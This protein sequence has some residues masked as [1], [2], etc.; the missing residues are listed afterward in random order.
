MV[1]IKMVE[2]YNDEQ[3]FIKQVEKIMTEM[4]TTD[5]KFAVAHGDRGNLYSAMILK[6]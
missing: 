5:V 4:D 6:H 2:E 1:Q 3:K